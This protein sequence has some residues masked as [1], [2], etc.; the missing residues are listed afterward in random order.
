MAEYTAKNPDP[1]SIRRGIKGALRRQFWLI[2]LPS[3]PDSPKVLV[4]GRSKKQRA[5][6]TLFRYTYEG[7]SYSQT[8]LSL[9]YQPHR[10]FWTP[11]GHLRTANLLAN[12]VERTII[13]LEIAIAGV[14]SPFPRPI[15]HMSIAASNA[16]VQRTTFIYACIFLLICLV[17]FYVTLSGFRATNFLEKH[18][19][20][21]GSIGSVSQAITVS[22]QAWTVIVLLVLSYAMQVVS[23]DTIVRR[24]KCYRDDSV[25]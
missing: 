21:I 16:F 25:S 1:N 5:R 11:L 18:L 19:F 22:T 6:S 23:S 9:S 2:P 10:E 7:D 17:L 8:S 4:T 20:D 12:F 3:D 15:R 14:R 13:G 24:S